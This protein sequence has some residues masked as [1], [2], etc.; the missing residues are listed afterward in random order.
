MNGK[1]INLVKPEYPLAAKK[2][3]VRG[4]VKVS[5]L[6][7]ENGKVIEAEAY[8][9][10]PLLKA[11]SVKAALESEFA[12]VTIGGNPVKVRGVIYYNYISDIYNWL[13]IGDG[14][15]G[16]RFLQMLPSGFDEEK[17]MFEQYQLADDDILIFQSLKASI[18]NKISNNPKKLWLFQVG[19]L[20]N[21]MRT[22]CCRDDNLKESIS[23][24]RMI[25]LYA[26]E[27]VS[28]S[29]I[30]KLKNLVWLSDNPQLNTYDPS[31]GNKFYQQLEDI[32]EKLSMLGD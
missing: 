22:N 24:L 19:I 10:H 1:A 8:S 3:N 14:L 11:N 17:Q 9:G 18:E 28:S 2:V 30:K 29:L 31:S 13:E 4:T 12:P 27:N 21:D 26:P 25:L 6:I 5:I 15:R 7:D 32:Y 23:N 20:L 16:G